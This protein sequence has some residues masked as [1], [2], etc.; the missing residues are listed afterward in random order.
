MALSNIIKEIQDIMRKD[1]GV[2]GDAQRIGQL[3]W[4]LFLKI[5]DDRELEL[6]ITEQDFISPLINV[7]WLNSDGESRISNDLRWRTWAGNDEGMTGD[8]LLQF[9]NDDLFPA[10]SGMKI[11]PLSSD[12]EV[13]RSRQM[14][15]SSVFNDSFQYMKSGT[16][17]RQV[18]N[19]IEKK[20]DFNDSRKRHL[21]GDIYEQILRD[22]QSAG[23]AG[24]YYTPRA[25]TEFAVQIVNPLLSESILD[26]ACGTGGFLTG[27]IDHIRSRQISTPAEESILQANIHGIE[28]KPLPHLLAMTN[29][30][31][32]GID[33]PW[34]IRRDNA[35]SRPLRDYTDSDRVDVILT[36]PPFGGTEED[37]I[38]AN[39]PANYRTKETADLFLV[40]IV[41]L[42]KNKGR[43]AVVLPDTIFFGDG[44]K[45]RVK[46][47][48]LSECN[49]HTIV[50]LPETVFAPYTTIATNILFFEKGTSTKEIWYF[51]HPLPDGY[52]AYSKTRPMQIEEFELEKNWWNNRK[53][54]EYSW[55]VSIEDVKKRGY[56]LD[57]KNPNKKKQLEGH[58]SLNLE[59]FVTSK[60]KRVSEIKRLIDTLRK[61]L[62]DKSE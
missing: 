22:L 23:N 34:G 9:V 13:L 52:K 26:P 37:G 47:L 28:K 2:D 3:G 56:N 21:F 39:F 29:M 16:I 6:E 50:R 19:V 46:E 42:L 25:A 24:E 38:E 54:T 8:E 33:T 62:L 31:L 32:H 10:I 17:L 55:L 53:E 35:L 18:V 14:L 40:L 4:M 27:A 41:N 44:I 61:T 36:N 48:L 59:K 51:E 15:I 30:I 12:N 1:V 7:K 49:L 20:I 58:P 60:N 45:S 43:A 57:I 11:I 5:W